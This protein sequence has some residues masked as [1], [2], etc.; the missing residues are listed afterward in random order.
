V[1]DEAFPDPLS[2]RLLFVRVI[3]GTPVGG[4][5]AGIVVGDVL[6][7]VQHMKARI[8]AAIRPFARHVALLGQRVNQERNRRGIA[9]APDFQNDV[10]RIAW[11]GEQL[12]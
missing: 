2:L 6:H 7:G 12:M 5:A 11:A 8:D 1:C 4:V 3:P 10:V 9:D